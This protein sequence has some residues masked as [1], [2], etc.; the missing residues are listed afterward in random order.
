[1]DLRQSSFF[2]MM[3]GVE[4]EIT[5]PNVVGSLDEALLMGPYDIALFALKSYDTVSALEGMAE[6]AEKLPPFLCLSNG[7]ENEIMIAN[8]LGEENVVYGTVTTAVGRRGA[9]NI[10]VERLRGMGVA[11]GHPLSE[12]LVRALDAS[13]LQCELFPNAQDMK[14]SKMLTNLIS[15]ATSAI[16]DM[17][18]GDIFAHPGLYWLEI[19]QL[20]ETLAVMRKQGIRVV[21]LPGTP[22]KALAFAVRW[23]PLFISRPLIQKAV[24]GGRGEKM[25]SFHIDLHSGRGKSEVSFL[26]GAVVRYG[27]ELGIPTPANLLLNEKLTALTLEHEELETFR[28]KPEKLL[29]EF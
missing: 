16:L 19:S 9:G 12:R 26:N 27:E 7:V 10:I 29:E 25:P 21:S 11:A 2:L 24:G 1:M 3:R 17:P 6:L 18:P 5:E 4:H 13:G 14:W 22:V 20:R 8:S 15:N 23:L 28:G